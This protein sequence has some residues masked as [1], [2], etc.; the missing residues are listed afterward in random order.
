[1][2]LNKGNLKLLLN[3]KKNIKTQKVQKVQKVYITKVTI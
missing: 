1:M 2:K 3:Y